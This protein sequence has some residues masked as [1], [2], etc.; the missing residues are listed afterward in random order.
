MQNPFIRSACRTRVGAFVL[1]S[2]ALL[3]SSPQAQAVSGGAPNYMIYHPYVSTRAL[4]MGDAFTAVADDYSALFYNPAG[5][6]RLKEGE[7]NLGIRAAADPQILTLSKDIENASKSN[8]LTDMSNLLEKNYG[9][10]Y[11]MR[12]PTVSAEWARPGWGFAIIPVDLSLELEIHKLGGAALDLTATQ[13]TTIAY[14]RGWDVHWLEGH[15]ISLGVTAKTIYRG[16][17]NREFLASE[18]MIDSK[19]LRP[20]DATEGMTFDA[21]LGMLWTPPET[22]SPWLRP[23]VGFTVHN[24][25]DLGFKSNLHL[26]DKNSGEA[27][28]LGRRFDVGTMWEL[29]DWWIWKTRLAADMRDMGDENWT[30]KKGLHLGA[31]FL[32]KVRSWWQGGWRIGVNQGYFTAGFTGMFGIFQAELATYAEETGTSANPGSNRKYMAK[33][34][35]DF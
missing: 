11:G 8:N 16:Y 6:A 26:I 13:D 2:F 12:A 22:W 30:A 31:E 34:A 29:P 18:L 4:G 20:E 1:G 3:L 7:V 10:H 24:V 23:T 9:M 32:W 14:G 5:L 28:K 27:P 21:D 15:H 35:L 17:Y 25:A 33:V 19:L